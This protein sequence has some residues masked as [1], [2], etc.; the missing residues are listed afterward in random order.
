MGSCMIRVYITL[1]DGSA[2]QLIQH[3]VGNTWPNNGQL[4]QDEIHQIPQ[5]LIDRL[6]PQC[7]ADYL[8]QALFSF[9]DRVQTVPQQLSLTSPPEQVNARPPTYANAVQKL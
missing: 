2:I 5:E 3:I 1:E 4:D 9:D 8:N 7:L 6:I